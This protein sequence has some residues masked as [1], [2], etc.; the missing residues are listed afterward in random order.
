[1][2]IFVVINCKNRKNTFVT[3]SARKAR[4]NFDFGSKIEVWYNDSCIETIYSK[5]LKEINKY[6]S[7]QRQHIGEK[8][9]KAEQRNGRKRK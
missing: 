7:L 9:S 1:M 2:M 4:N 3:T 5:T 6:V 8:Q